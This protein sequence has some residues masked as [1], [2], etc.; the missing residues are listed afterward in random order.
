MYRIPHEQMHTKAKSSNVG[1][2]PCIQRKG[3][4]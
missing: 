4:I 2:A 3:G 1:T